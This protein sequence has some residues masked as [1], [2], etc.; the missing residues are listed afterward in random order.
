MNEG[1]LKRRIQYCLDNHYSAEGAAN[2]YF[3]DLDEIKKDFYNLLDKMRQDLRNHPE[4]ELDYDGE[5][6]I[7]LKK[8][9]GDSD[10]CRKR[11][12][13]GKK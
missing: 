3:Q 12:K 5:Y 7:L 10:E 13:E 6:E 2:C 4:P 8:W 11:Q 1:E 9:F